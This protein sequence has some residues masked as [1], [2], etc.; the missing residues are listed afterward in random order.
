[1][2]E[3]NIRIVNYGA[4]L[5]L[6]TR[7]ADLVGQDISPDLKQRA[8]QALRKKKLAS[9][10]CPEGILVAGTR[11]IQPIV[12]SEDDLRLDIRDKG[13]TRRLHFSDPDEAAMLTQ[14]LERCLLIEI[15]RRTDLWTLDSPRIFYA[16]TPFKKVD[17]V[18]AYRRYEVSSIPIEGVGVGLVIDVSTAFFT[19]PT[20]ADF[21]EGKGKWQF[22]DFGT[23][24]SRQT[25][26]KAPYSMI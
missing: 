5:S 23:L 11:P 17:S 10:P 16:S 7:V 21:F 8:C 3:T 6:D 12:I 24:S 13:A 1:M 15:S 26:Q 14:L 2:I 9:V 20:V 19:I 22:R 25:G 4:K 18:A